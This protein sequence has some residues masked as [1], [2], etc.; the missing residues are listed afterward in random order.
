MAPRS[1]ACRVL[2]RTSNSPPDAQAE[3]QTTMLKRKTSSGALIQPSKRTCHDI[4]L[5]TCPLVEIFREYGLLETIFGGLGPDDL[6]ALL[7]SSKAIHQALVPRSGSLENLLGKLHCSGSGVNIRNKIHK[8]STFFYTY[9]CKEY[10][11]CSATV[12]GRCVETRPCV[13][14]RVATCDE[15]RIH[16]V[17]QSNFENPCDEDELPNFSGYVL[18]SAPE[19]PILSPHHLA[20]DE[21]TPRWQDPSIGLTKPYHDQ[22]FIDTPFEDD[23]FGP[24]EDVRALLDIDLGRH[25]L[26]SS[27]LSNVLDPSP[28]LRALHQATEQRK[29]KF[30]DACLPPELAKH[31]KGGKFHVCQC[32]L[33]SHF[34]NRWLCL[35]CYET[36][37]ASITKAYP[38]HRHRCDCQQ[39]VGNTVCMWC[40]GS[41]IDKEKDYQERVHA[42]NDP[43]TLGE[44]L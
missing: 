9:K 10:V 33:K 32:T 29:R 24:P 40:Y 12:K 28:V 44:L 7:L 30:C 41:V 20:P 26:A 39:R 35:R 18:L 42:Q 31:S 37:V 5:Q 14:C 16:C 38:N 3:Q 34:L 1:H 36:E 15:C 4:L 8:K 17:Y 2:S 13:K 43:N 6:L 19:T 21:A 27:A 11:Q 22:G 23:A 25:V